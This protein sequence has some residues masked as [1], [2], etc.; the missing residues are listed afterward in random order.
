MKMITIETKLDKLTYEV[1]S[2]IGK[3]TKAHSPKNFKL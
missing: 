3:N 2:S 1:I